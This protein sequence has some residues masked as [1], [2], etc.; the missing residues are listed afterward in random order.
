MDRAY[1]H[2]PETALVVSFGGQEAPEKRAVIDA[3][4]EAGLEPWQYESHYTAYFANAAADGISVVLIAMPIMAEAILQG[5]A[6]AFV[7]FVGAK[8]LSLFRSQ[9]GLTMDSARVTAEQVLVQQSGLSKHDLRERFAMADGD[10]AFSFGYTD[11]R[12]GDEHFVLVGAGGATIHVN[13]TWLEAMLE[14]LQLR[15][16]TGDREDGIAGE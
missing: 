11:A 14:R 8:F 6:E 16:T 10:G 5:T 1:G 13:L 3:A 4:R 12:S 15:L 9:P 7:R 2:E